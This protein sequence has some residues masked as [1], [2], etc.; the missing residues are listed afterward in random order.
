M[1]TTQNEYWI[2]KEPVQS[3]NGKLFGSLKEWVVCI[4]MERCLRYDSKWKQ[5]IEEQ[6]VWCNLV[7]KEIC[8]HINL[9]RKLLKF[10]KGVLRSSCL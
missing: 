4:N 8:I 10:Y 6:F 9:N 1:H 5:K 3:Y 2:L 7:L